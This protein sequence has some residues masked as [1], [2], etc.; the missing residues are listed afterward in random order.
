MFLDFC[1]C[2]LSPGCNHFVLHLSFPI[3]PLKLCILGKFFC[4]YSK[5][6]KLFRMISSAYSSFLLYQS[7]ASIKF[8]FKLLGHCLYSRKF[9]IGRWKTVS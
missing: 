2:Y 8:F 6:V 4:K 5:M 1:F 9:N 3:E 7:A